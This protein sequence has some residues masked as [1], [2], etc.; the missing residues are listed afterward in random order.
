MGHKAL[1]RASGDLF[2]LKSEANYL[3]RQVSLSRNNEA[4]LLDI[5]QK[6]YRKL[7]Q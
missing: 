7:E 2:Q 3:E 4:K 5:C 1:S 6:V